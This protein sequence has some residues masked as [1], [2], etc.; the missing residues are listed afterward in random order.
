MCEQDILIYLKISSFLFYFIYSFFV[1][2]KS[3]IH[4]LIYDE[5]VV[6][7]RLSILDSTVYFQKSPTLPCIYILVE[8]VFGVS[9]VCRIHNEPLKW[10]APLL[11]KCDYKVCVADNTEIRTHKMAAQWKHIL[12]G[13]LHKPFQNP[14]LKYSRHKPLLLTDNSD[15]RMGTE[16]V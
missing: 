7:S 15:S 12:I 4:E 3:F 16:L 1:S 9:G 13:R 11:Q 6:S 2:S 5:T 8:T 14:T 10:V